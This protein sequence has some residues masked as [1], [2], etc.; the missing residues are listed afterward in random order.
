MNSRLKRIAKECQRMKEAGELRGS[1]LLPENFITSTRHQ[2]TWCPLYKAGSTTWMKMMLLLEG[3][4]T[5][6][7][8]DWNNLATSK[9]S[10]NYQETIAHLLHGEV[11][12]VVRDPWERLLSAYRNK[13]EVVMNEDQ[14]AF[15]ESYGRKMV[16]KYR[17]EGIQRFGEALYRKNAGAPIDVEGRNLQSP[18]FWEFARWIID[19]GEMD[20]HWN[21]YYIHCNLCHT[22]YTAILKLEHLDTEEKMFLSRINGTQNHHLWK[23]RSPGENTADLLTLYY[24]TLSITELLQLQHTYHPDFRLFGYSQSRVFALRQFDKN[25]R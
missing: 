2:L 5:A 12:L 14:V 4:D 25:G 1:W 13:L 24:G 20:R 22:K 19:G 6:K 18:T 10:H 11:L 17:Q 23:N 15:L 21:P 9:M 3:V 8:N 16:A 7:R